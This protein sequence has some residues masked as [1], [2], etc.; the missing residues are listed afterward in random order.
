MTS[1]PQPEAS[2]DLNSGLSTMAPCVMLYYMTQSR[3]IEDN[4]IIAVGFKYFVLGLQTL[5]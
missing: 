5:L 1:Y 3:L 2:H 4:R